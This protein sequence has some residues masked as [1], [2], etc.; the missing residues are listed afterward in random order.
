MLSDQT[1]RRRYKKIY[2]EHLQW[3][4]D[5]RQGAYISEQ[6]SKAIEKLCSESDTSILGKN[7]FDFQSSMLMGKVNAE[8][9]NRDA[10]IES[11]NQQLSL[12]LSYCII[13]LNFARLVCQVRGKPASPI[14]KYQNSSNFI[15]VGLMLAMCLN[16]ESA[17]AFLSDFL[18]E[19]IET[20]ANDGVPCDASLVNLSLFLAC[21]YQG[22]DEEDYPALKSYRTIMDG[23]TNNDGELLGS[24]LMSALDYHVSIAATDTKESAK[25]AAAISSMPFNDAFSS[26]LLLFPI[27]IM[28]V[29]SVANRR[30]IKVET[31]NHPMWNHADYEA[32][33]GKLKPLDIYDDFRDLG[34]KIL[35]SNGIH[36]SY[37]SA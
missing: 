9:I 28:A 2:R 25:E 35:R 31:L 34:L 13:S 26:C 16:D 14:F 15:A 21:L 20:K 18:K 6:K 8:M 10:N 4:D 24:G 1:L 7:E 17:V 32:L 23:L 37:H 12:S 29:L 36:C 30:K 27:E 22:L 5:I 33:I 3:W 19:V 11:I